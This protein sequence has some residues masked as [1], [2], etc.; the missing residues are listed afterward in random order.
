[1]PD[2]SNLRRIDIAIERMPRAVINKDLHLRMC[3]A[4]RL[5]QIIYPAAWPVTG[6]QAQGDLELAT[7]SFVV[8]GADDQ[9]RAEEGEKPP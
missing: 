4:N 9:A 3:R 6:P 7:W 1:M 2:V 5:F 8:R